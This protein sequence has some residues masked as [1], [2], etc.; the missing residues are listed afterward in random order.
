[1]QTAT[2][3][4]SMRDLLLVIRRAN[5]DPNAPLLQSHVLFHEDPF[6]KTMSGGDVIRGSGQ[7]P[8]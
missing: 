2:L 7:Q 3:N 8:F 1:M 4:K 6:I 5:Y